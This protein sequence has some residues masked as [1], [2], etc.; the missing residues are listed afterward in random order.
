VKNDRRGVLARVVYG[1]VLVVVATTAYTMFI[2]PVRG[3]RVGI[4]QDGRTKYMDMVNGTAW[5]PF[6]YR[7]LLPTTIRLIS[8]A[9]PQSIKQAIADEAESHP[10]VRDQF[11]YLRWETS[12]AYEYGV[13]SMLMILCYIGFA[14][15]TTELTFLLTPVQR[16][17]GMRLLLTSIVLLGL[18]AFF[19]FTMFPYD[20][21]Q[22]LFFTL[23][24]YFLATGRL[25]A[26]A[27]AFVFCCVNK[28]TAALLILL[29]AVVG[30]QQRLPS[31]TYG[32]LLV[33][34]SV[35]YV[36][37][38][39]TIT[40]VYRG[41]PG[42]LAEFQFAHNYEWLTR[43][44]AFED[45]VTFF[46]IACLLFLYWRQ[47]APFLRAAFLCTLPIQLA[48]G[49]FWGFLNEWRVYYEA[50]PVCFALMVDSVWRIK[51]RLESDASE[52]R[53]AV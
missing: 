12:A 39:G 30:R 50:Y 44:W 2:R 14:Y 47:K 21:P 23:A 52:T 53:V 4:N 1:V 16:S 34:L 32:G 26:F 45:L 29:F 15:T 28:E 18:G 9:T 10:F 22:L 40:Y 31:R 11:A 25:T 46:V 36:V 8:H 42:V 20:P 6:V 19:R 35:V 37:I 5:R 49:V 13:G 33:G 51:N 41:N 38:K 17:L 43:A 24:L 7:T 3:L 27:I 48:L